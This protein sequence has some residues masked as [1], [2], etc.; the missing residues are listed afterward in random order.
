MFFTSF[1][2]YARPSCIIILTMTR[3]IKV[4]KHDVDEEN[5]GVKHIIYI[6]VLISFSVNLLYHFLSAFKEKFSHVSSGKLFFVYTKRIILYYSL[7]FLNFFPGWHS[8]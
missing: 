4:A 6:I 3:R 7:L 2:A 1:Y 5:C 8:I